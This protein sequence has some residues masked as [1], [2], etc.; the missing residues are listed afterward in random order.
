[1]ARVKLARLKSLAYKFM[2][3]RCNVRVTRLRGTEMR[4]D[5]GEMEGRFKI[6]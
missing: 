1:M 3:D 2:G 5:I 4:Q 6:P